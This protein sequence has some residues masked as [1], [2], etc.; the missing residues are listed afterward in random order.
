MG[1]A[2]EMLSHVFDLFWQAEHTREQTQGGLG[3][4]L[5]LVRKLAELHGGSVIAH[6]DGLSH[7]S[8]FV[9][10]LPAHAEAANGERH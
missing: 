4:G 6:S 3:I 2:P 8:E 9:V 1:I 5:A 7:G 10:R